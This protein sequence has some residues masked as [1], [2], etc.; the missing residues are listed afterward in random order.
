MLVHSELNN[1]MSDK[2]SIR[3]SDKI[4]SGLDISCHRKDINATIQ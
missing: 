4:K 1:L 2:G 3:E